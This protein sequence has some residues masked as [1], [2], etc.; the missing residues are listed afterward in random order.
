MYRSV[1]IRDSRASLQLGSS[2]WRLSWI[3][4]IFLPATFIVGFFGM[5]VETFAGGGSADIKWF[6][7]VLFPF[8]AVVIIGWYIL[9]HLLAKNRRTPVQRGLYEALYT[10]LEGQNPLLWTRQGPREYVVPADWVSRV[11]WRLI[12]YWAKAD[13]RVVKPGEVNE[14]IGGWERIKRWL[15]DKWTREIKV[16]KELGVGIGT[17]RLLGG[18]GLE[19]GEVMTVEN[20]NAGRVVPMGR[21]IITNEDGEGGVQTEVAEPRVDGG[22]S[23]EGSPTRGNVAMLASGLAPLEPDE[24]S[25]ILVEERREDEGFMEEEREITRGDYEHR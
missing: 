22:G 14:P 8:F 10:H 15:M 21:V 17:R 12:R 11:K 18:E 16:V 19:L 3:T 7:I 20:P 25:E 24:N 23:A 9:K 13:N 2:M 6:F 5:N 1:A 4:F